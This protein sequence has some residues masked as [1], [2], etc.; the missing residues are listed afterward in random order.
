MPLLDPPILGGAGFN[1]PLALPSNGAGQRRSDLGGGSYGPFFGIGYA[2]TRHT[3]KRAQPHSRVLSE[4]LELRDMARRLLTT[5]TR[6][7]ARNFSLVAWMVRCHLDNVSDFAFRAKTKDT[8]FNVALNEWVDNVWSLPENFDSA[9]R[10]SFPDLRRLWAAHATFDGDILISRLKNGRV[11]TIEGDRIQTWGGIPFEQLGI[12]DASW[13][14]NGVW[15]NEYGKPIGYMVFRRPPQWGGLLWDRMVPA[16]FADMLGYYFRYDQLRGISPLSSCANV[17]RDVYE[18]F[19]LALAKMKQIQYFGIQVTRAA[20]DEFGAHEVREGE[21]DPLD[22]PAKPRY[23]IDLGAG[24]WINEMDPG[25]EMKV[26]ESDTPSTSSQG[27]LQAMILVGLKAL[28]L[29][30]SFFDESHTNF[31][32]SR[33]AGIRYEQSCKIKRHRL[34][35]LLNKIT[36]WRLGLAIADGEIQLPGSMQ[37]ADVRFDWAHSGM[38]LFNPIQEISADVAEINAG[39]SSPQKKCRERGTDFHE[40]VDE[41]AEAQKYASSRGVTLSTAL[42]TNAALDPNK[43]QTQTEDQNVAADED[44]KAMEDSRRMW[45]GF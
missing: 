22:D 38:P 40:N 27:F 4:D 5:S 6:D 35:L 42:A 32:G 36:R 39:I 43:S 20:G 26:V 44:K 45:S 15:T 19:D 9:G 17:L 34:R 10:H 29:P 31:A 30:F 13:V 2:A 11:Q 7:L 12:T 37:P 1:A 18:G 3:G 33:M 23:S 25:D 28:D 8:G 14:Q 41:T 16:K 24:P 21:T